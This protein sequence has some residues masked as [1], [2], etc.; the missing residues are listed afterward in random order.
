[1]K[2]P[3]KTRELIAQLNRI[4]LEIADFSY[5]KELVRELPDQ[6]PLALKHLV[7]TIIAPGRNHPAH[8]HRIG[9]HKLF[10]TVS[11]GT[12]PSAIDA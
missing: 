3:K 6:V 10:R 4:D 9:R 2:V 11:A 7:V 1:M 12:H 8:L 5:V